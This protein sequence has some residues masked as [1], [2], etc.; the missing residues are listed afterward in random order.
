[1]HGTVMLMADVLTAVTALLRRNGNGKNGKHMALPEHLLAEIREFDKKNGQECEAF[2]L[3]VVEYNPHADVAKLKKAYVFSYNAHHGQTRH[4]GEFFFMH[5][6]ET[7]KILT[8]LKADSASLCAALL[9]DCVEDCGIT[10]D[11]LKKEFG[12]EITS[13]VDGV[14]KIQAQF[15]T[16]EAYTA[17]NIR[18]ILLA[19]AKDVRVILIKLADRLHNMRTLNASLFRPDKIQ[20]IARETRDIYAPL[21]HKLGMR[22][23]KGELEDLSFKTLESEAY[24][25]IRGRIVEKRIEREK[26]TKELIAQIKKRLEAVHV[27]ADI[28]GRAKYFYSIYQKMR[29]KQKDFSEIYDLIAIRIMVNTISECYTA[30]GIVHEL[31]KPIPGRFKDYISVPKTNGYQS[32][33]TSV[34]SPHGKIIEIQ[35]RTKEMHNI[36]EDGIAAHWRY[37]GKERDKRFDRK[38]S[39]LKQLLEWKQESKNAE[40]FV[41][42]LRIDLFENEIVLFTPKGDP[43]SLPEGSTPIDFAYA[44]HTNIGNHCS[45]AEVNG[46]AVPLDAM[47]KSGDV[48]KIQMQKNTR[49]ARAWLSFVKSGKARSKIKSILKIKTETSGGKDEASTATVRLKEKIIVEGL[50]IK[51]NQLKFSKCCEPQI[52]TPIRAFM[53]KDKKITI[54]ATS[55]P[56]CATLNQSKSFVATWRDEE[57]RGNVQKIKVIVKDR[58][59]LLA[60]ILN[61]IAREK[62]N[63]LSVNTRSKKERVVI[64]FKVDVP[65]SVSFENVLTTIR[66]IDN[67]IDVKKF[68][69]EGK[70]VSTAR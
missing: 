48:V 36:A 19:T 30:L 10:L 50:K 57:T 42:T 61:L 65:S 66:I 47:L 25:K 39:W 45:R 16:R 60:E 24:Q 4:S 70:E 18:K 37:K 33:H 3:S 56:N 21:A 32:L 1:M 63:V 59:G 40:D 26:N 12:E 20:R 22:S 8:G 31:W 17:E 53:T 13:L 28:V 69:S 7:A 46:L 49:P 11:Q 41:E 35:I 62:I 27:A 38:L 52:K 2:I 34:V 68:T 58:V 67:V 5:P 23:I 15:E 6:M 54:H 14:T 55:C 29:K 51:P 43:I 64:T 44:V 9:H